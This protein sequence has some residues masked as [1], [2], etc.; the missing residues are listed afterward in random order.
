MSKLVDKERLARLAQGLYTKLHNEVAA[1][2]TAR[3]ALDARVVVLEEKFK[4]DN[5]VEKLIEAAEGRAKTHAENKDAELESR[6]QLK[7]DA[8][9]DK[10]AYDQHVLDYG[11]KVAALEAEDARV[12]GL[13]T[14]EENRAKGEEARIEGLV[15]AE[16]AKAREEEGK[17]SDR[18][19]KFE[20]GNDSVA[21]VKAEL[22]GKITAVDG[23]ADKNAAD[24]LTEKGRAEGAE[25]ELLA[26]I[27]KEI[28]DRGTAVQG[29]QGEVDTLE[30]VVAQQKTDLQAEIALKADKTALEAEVEARG[31]AEA[32][33]QAAIEKEAKD[34]RAAEQALGE[35]IDALAGE[36]EGSIKDQIADAIAQEVL[37][38]DAA[39]LV[40]TNRATAKENEIVQAMADE[41]SRVNTK[42]STD[43]A[44]EAA[45]REAADKALENRIKVFEGEGEGSVAAQIQAAKDYADEQITALVNGA[46][47]AMNTLKELADAIDTH[48]DAYE[49]YVATVAQDIAK[50]KADAIA[51]AANKDAALKTELQKEIDD[52]VKVVADA[53]ANEKNA[54]IQ[55][56]LAQKIAAEVTRADAEEK[57]I[58]KAFADA[59]SELEVRVNAAI[60]VNA[61]EIAK[62]KDAEQAGT[63]ANQ[64]KVEKGRAEGQ[65]AAIRQEFAAADT[66]L[67]N[68]IGA[69]EDELNPEKEGFAKEVNG[70]IAAA[71]GRLD[72]VEADITTLEGAVEDLEDAIAGDISE[73]LKPYAKTDDVKTMLSGVVQSLGIQIADN[74][75]KLTLGGGSSVVTIKECELEMATDADIDGIIAG[76]Q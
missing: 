33:L 21:A 70:E 62:Q 71:K 27:N 63:L 2:A 42:I 73:A 7:L 28:E 39:I 60:K 65:E 18:I 30:G 32:A 51:D 37:D 74:K 16:A 8:K 76:L 10:S 19:A 13:V 15:T 41:A 35:R 20:T 66:A 12:A 44:A 23:K 43:I 61:D 59:D 31:V 57:A 50:A 72:L 68:R 48:Q 14:S 29:V 5:S 67:G 46:P 45:L 17:L 75:I 40:E 4:G 9:A 56:S 11:Q 34:A 49:A 54:E 69:V 6:V 22:E 38:R 24:I 47:E 52:D 64:I 25:A 1:E 58:R 36:D 55:G 53:L 3:G 26:K